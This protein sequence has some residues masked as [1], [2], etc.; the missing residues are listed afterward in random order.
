LDTLSLGFSENVLR[1]LR[2]NDSGKIV[3]KD[4][5]DLG[6]NMNDDEYL[7]KN[8]DELVLSFTE[9]LSDLLRDE[10]GSIDEAGVLID[11]SQTFLNVF[12]IDFQEDQGSINTHI[13]WELS[14]YFP[15]SYKE[16]NIKYYRLHNKYL[17][18]GID[19]VLLIAVD[20]NKI[21]FI[22]NLCNG[23]GIKI[24]NVD[25]DQFIVEKC[26]REF[27]PAELKERTV[28]LGGCKN[29]RLDFS[30]I[31]NE[32][33]K[34]YD[35][36]NAGT[37]NINTLLVKQMNFFNSMFNEDPPG[38]IFLYGD[39]NA[40]VVKNFLNE[41]FESLPVILIDPFLKTGSEENLS[42]Y[43]PLYGLALK[44]FG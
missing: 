43:A 33:I 24:K 8:R 30:L 17:S 13:L 35:Y 19:E 7:R 20:K 39:Q 29:S 16:F 25:I 40:E 32:K 18:D 22:K 9:K 1:I 41:K 11:T 42:K 14:N 12:P 44:N 23:S 38:I 28:L 27:Y 3:F 10:T 26:V 36:E 5:I 37:S 4:E 34:Y 21:E 6:F 31:T 2:L 15:G